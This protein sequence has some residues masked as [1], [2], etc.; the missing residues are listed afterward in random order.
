[1]VVKDQANQKKIFHKKQPK[2]WVPE[3]KQKLERGGME[4]E[5]RAPVGRPGAVFTM[6]KL[7]AGKAMKLQKR[8]NFSLPQAAKEKEKSYYKKLFKEREEVDG[9]IQLP[10]ATKEREEV[11]YERMSKEHEEDQ[12][13]DKHDFSIKK[14]QEETYRAEQK[15]LRR[16]KEELEREAISD[17][18][19]K[20]V[21][22]TRDSVQHY[23]PV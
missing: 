20:G 15:A 12:V 21:E 4:E 7:D 3:L 11:Y 2:V 13:L 22:R 6:A 10:Q 17:T 1:M 9:N 16:V 18:S 5:A 14:A 8:K 19:V 23:S